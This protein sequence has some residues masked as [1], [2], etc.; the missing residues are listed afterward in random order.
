MKKAVVMVL[1]LMMIFSSISAGAA[2]FY[3]YK[4]PC[5]VP[6]SVYREPYMDSQISTTYAPWFKNIHLASKAQLDRGDYA[7]EACQQIR[8]FAVSPI[9]PDIMYFG[10]DT[11]GIYTTANGGKNWFNTNNGY[12]GFYSQGIVFESDGFEKIAFGTICH[13]LW[14]EGIRNIQGTYGRVCKHLLFN[15]TP[16]YYRLDPEGYPNSEFIAAHM[17]QAMHYSM[18]YPEN[19]HKMAAAIRKIAENKA[20]LM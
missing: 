6:A 7:G 20:E 14:M 13:A 1:A 17:I 12:P 5:E 4:N 11:N 8:S 16:E 3:Q 15:M 18:Y 9:N 10:T 19:A 2:E